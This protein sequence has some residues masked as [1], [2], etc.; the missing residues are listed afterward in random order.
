MKKTFLTTGFI[1]LVFCVAAQERC[2]GLGLGGALPLGVYSGVETDEGDFKD[3]GF[4]EYGYTMK[5]ID[6]QYR[7]YKNIGA[8]YSW[9]RHNHSLDENAYT[10]EFIK[11]EAEG[12]RYYL[13]PETDDD[14]WSF[15]THTVG[16]FVSTSS[17]PFEFNTKASVAVS[18]GVKTPELNVTWTDSIDPLVPE[19][20][21]SNTRSATSNS[22]VGFSLGLGGKYYI[23][24]HWAIT[25]GLDYFALNPKLPIR[26]VK[27]TEDTGSYYKNPIEAK[28]INISFITISFG[29]GYVW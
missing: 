20:G 12:G 17:E 14:Y 29:L 5:L 4:A 28:K 18:P 16:F 25:A 15:S 27:I 6:V 1:V 21:S 7:F 24:N 26:R 22:N 10:N 8:S 9:W 3:V 11:V 23:N 2:I 13:D 19:G